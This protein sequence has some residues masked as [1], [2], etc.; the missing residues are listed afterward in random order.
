[1]FSPGLP[2]TSTVREL[3]GKER[4]S[5]SFMRLFAVRTNH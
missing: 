5:W 1:M 2:T 3:C 4:Q